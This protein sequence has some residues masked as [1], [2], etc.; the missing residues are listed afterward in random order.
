MASTQEPVHGENLNLSSIL[1]PMILLP[2]TDQSLSALSRL[3]GIS[4]TLKI[5]MKTTYIF[6][7]RY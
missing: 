1:L 2:A 7:T 5:Y 6:S 4:I 3:Q